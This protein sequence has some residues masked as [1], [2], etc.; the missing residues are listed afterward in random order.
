MDPTKKELYTA[1]RSSGLD[2]DNEEVKE[3][4]REFRQ[5]DRSNWLLLKL[6][7]ANGIE[8]HGVGSGG[9]EEM[10]ASLSPTE[11]YYGAIKAKVSELVRFYHINIIG[12][13]IGGMKRG[14]AAMHKP[15]IFGLIEAHGEVNC[16]NEVDQITSQYVIEEISRITKTKS[17]S[18]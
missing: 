15:A 14:K 1:K 16:P 12:A 2:T 7:T 3:A 18:I 11:V 13:E 17:V 8:L 4:I 6:T 10:V 5:G 9:L